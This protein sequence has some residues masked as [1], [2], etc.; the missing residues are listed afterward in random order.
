M[1]TT[2][3]PAIALSLLACDPAAARTA[4]REGRHP[5]RR[6]DTR[7]SESGVRS[8]GGRQEAANAV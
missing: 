8:G 5:A 3:S 6:C 4:R 1:R 2:P 7:H